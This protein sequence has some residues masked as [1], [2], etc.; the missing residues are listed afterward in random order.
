M[1]ASKHR[2]ARS[3]TK[4][5][6]S[7]KG[8]I[9]VLSAAFFVVIMAFTAFTVDVGYIALTKAELKNAAD[10][11]ALAAAAELPAGF[12]AG[13]EL[14]LAEVDAIARQAAVDVAGANPA[15]D[16]SSVYADGDR[17]VRFGQIQW[18]SDSQSWQKTWGVAPYNLVEV[19]PRR[20]EE[21]E[22][23]EVEEPVPNSGGDRPLNLF[24]APVI[25][26]TKAGLA[27][28]S[29]AGMLPGAGFRIRSG[30]G[31]TVGVLPIALDDPTWNGV[32]VGIG[33]DEWTY[34][35]DTGAITPGPDGIV[36]A[37]LYPHGSAI[38]PPGNRGTVDL[39]SSNNSTND[40][41]R[42][43][44]YGL[45]EYD[46]SFFGGELRFDQGPLYINGDTGLS[47]AIKDEL[48]QI[49]GQPRAIPIF[50][51][52]SGPGNNA[53]YTIT[54]FVGIRILDVQLTGSPSKKHVTVQP[55][56]YVDATVVPGDVT[57]SEDTIFTQPVLVQ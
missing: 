34:D 36:E 45:N 14:N 48:N 25:G 32:L 43:I 3:R 53:T 39:G 26:H 13:A 29:S 23:P 22:D 54:K 35:P 12:G 7:R 41:K 46:L 57:I 50:T 16:L 4:S 19:S 20:N 24:F 47:A 42:Q 1:N 11:A 31:M 51:A 6:G 21:F 55:A 33:P 8:N 49:K 30:S 28:S 2:S 18:D 9:L 40:I 38:M 37:N 17:D 15:G 44:L 56:P 5:R 10:A 27:V 52:V